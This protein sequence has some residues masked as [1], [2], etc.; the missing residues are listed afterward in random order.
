MHHFQRDGHMQYG[1][2]E[3][4]AHYEPNSFTGDD[5]GPRADVEDGF[6]ST[7]AP[8]EGAKRRI[9][10]ES[11][12]DHY[13]QA[14]QFYVSQTPL[15]QDHIV[16]AFVFELGKCEIADIRTR[17]LANLANVHDD[18][19]AR[20]ADGLGMPLPEPSPAAV[21]TRTDLPPSDAL[22]ILKNGPASFKGRKLGILVTDNSDAALVKAVK[23][24]FTRGGA[25]VELIGPKIGGVK[26]GRSTMP[27]DHA[28]AAA[29]SVL[30]DAVAL[31]PSMG[32]AAELALMKPAQDFVADAYAHLKIIGH[33]ADA[34]ALLAAVGLADKVDDGFVGLT[35]ETADAFFD[36][37]GALRFWERPVKP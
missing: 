14:R 27:V 10:A 9:R 37:C 19:A 7:A 28:V 5:R 35:A 6:R 31:L 3:G 18:L 15:E 22:S 34:A 25:V 33:N 12:A 1:L 20:V 2:Q 17:M 30:F 11:F 23:A 16:D 26:V 21:A 32:G 29:P 36:A 4:R 13:S 8:V 24:A